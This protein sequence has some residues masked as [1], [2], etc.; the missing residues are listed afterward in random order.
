MS[1]TT[2]D[3]S[4]STSPMMIRNYKRKNYYNN[5]I[6]SFSSDTAHLGFGVA[7]SY[8][9]IRY[10]WVASYMFKHH[11]NFSTNP[12]KAYVAFFSEP[13][14]IDSEYGNVPYLVD[15]F[16]LVLKSIPR[17]KF[18]LVFHELSSKQYNAMSQEFVNSDKIEFLLLSGKIY[19]DQFQPAV[20]GDGVDGN[21][22]VN[23]FHQYGDAPVF[24]VAGY[25]YNKGGP[26]EKF[27]FDNQ[28][29]EV[30][31]VLNRAE[32]KTNDYQQDVYTTDEFLAS[33]V[34]PIEYGDGSI[35]V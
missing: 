26:D 31:I 4:I 5:L 14:I 16:E 7:K 30:D 29:D 15:Q 32:L 13:D 19:S 23:I 20:L 35:V 10:K 12:H 18:P 17:T 33:L 6:S 34:S 21:R 27:S 25:V 1:N 2:L 9:S 11:N 28:I 24:A 8:S 3:Y 22:V